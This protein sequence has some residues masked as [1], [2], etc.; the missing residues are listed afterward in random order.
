MTAASFNFVSAV[1]H[2]VI[3]VDLEVAEVE[4]V[5]DLADELFFSALDDGDLHFGSIQ[6]GNGT[7]ARSVDFQERLVVEVI[8][9]LIS[10]V[11]LDLE[12]SAG[13]IAELSDAAIGFFLADEESLALLLALAV[14]TEDL[15]GVGLV[16]TGDG[17]SPVDL[18][19][20]KDS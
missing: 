4:G 8:E 13:G 14:D 9:V 5:D 7:G 16:A 2:G 17:L 10:R 18:L 11:N 19:S 15:V 20:N 12:G 6:A 3:E 1:A